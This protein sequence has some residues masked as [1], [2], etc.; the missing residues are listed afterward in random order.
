MQKQSITPYI[1]VKGVSHQYNGI[2]VLD[3]VSCAIEKGS[4]TAII[5]PNGSG[6]TTLI[7]TILGLLS[8]TQGTIL[9]EGKPPSEMRTHIGYVPQQ[10]QF[11]RTLPIT[12]NEFLKTYQCK[13]QKHRY[14][15]IT[16]VLKE[17]GLGGQI[18]Q[19]IGTLS[20]GQFQRALIA[21]AIFHEKDI[22]VLDEPSAGID[23]E[24][25]QSLYELIER[26]H[27]EHGTTCIIISHDVAIVHRFADSVICLNKKKICQGAPS[28][29]ITPE[30]LKQLYGTDAGV[31]RHHH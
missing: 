31:Y 1:E 25:E 14:K 17:V 15:N 19:K 8:P 3:R 21:R 20:G 24:G 2:A 6:K 11:D 10:L 12:V 18:N 7:R 4:I 22:L 9:I 28:S 29:T 23:I 16:Q 13:D 27:D 26:L 30:V 5:G